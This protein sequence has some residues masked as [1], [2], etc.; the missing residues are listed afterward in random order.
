MQCSCIL[1]FDGATKG[2]PG[3]AGAGVVLRNSDGAL[4]S[5]YGLKWPNYKFLI[6]QFLVVWLFKLQH[7]NPYRYVEFVKAWELLPVM[8]LNIMPLF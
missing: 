1:H 8:L 5:W 6:S 2:N 3:P 7:E 4:V